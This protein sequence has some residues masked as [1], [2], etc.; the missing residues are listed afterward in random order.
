M[1]VMELLGRPSYCIDFVIHESEN[2][3]AFPLPPCVHHVLAET[4]LLFT[5]KSFSKVCLNFFN[6]TIYIRVDNMPGNVG[7]YYPT[8]K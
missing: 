1:S 2:T 6:A 5:L 3:A 7:F 4:E 8:E